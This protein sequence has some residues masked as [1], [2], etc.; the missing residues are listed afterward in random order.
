METL[1][2]LRQQ[3]QVQVSRDQTAQIRLETSEATRMHLVD[4]TMFFASEG[5][6][7]GRYLAAK[8][9]WLLQHSSIRH[10]ILAPGARDAIGQP[11]LVTVASPALP[12]L[13]GY[14]FPVRL[15]RWTECLV[16]LNPDVIEAGDPYGP[17]WAALRA[18]QRL[19]VPVVGFYHSDL[20]RL[21]GSRT[22]RWSEPAVARY[23]RSLYRHF[24]LVIAPSRYVFDKLADLGLARLACRP[25]GVDVKMFHPS[26][27][28]RGLRR[29]LGLAEDTRL[30]IFA[31]RFA[32]EKNLRVLLE[33]FKR[34]GARYHL[35]LVGSGMDLPAQ[36][37]A[38]V[39]P[40]QRSPEALAR[41][42]AS[43][44][45]LVHGGD[46]ETF[47]LIVLEAM[48]CGRPVVAAN[49]GGLA[50]LVTSDT[51]VLAA[52]RDA[53]AL[54]AAVSGLYA[55]DIEAMGQRA[56]RHVEAAF[57]WDSVMRSLMMCYSKVTAAEPVAELESYAV[58]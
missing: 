41:L 34:L 53:S 20:V 18:G 19:G 44:D 36:R 37:N 27:A 22:G 43:S 10:T 24:D 47:G 45:L 8:H 4:T 38:T 39:L 2:E 3:R 48:A 49:S 32:R 16:A 21:I 11:G 46:Q 56:R 26:R 23:V 5:G 54:A 7:V 13:Q 51:G 31:G 40:Y 15:A 17:A 1:A 30:A 29:E 42:L 28:D 52:P 9:D 55:C 14:R 35:L 12:G 6:G 25:L 33:A 50:E 58:R 57:S